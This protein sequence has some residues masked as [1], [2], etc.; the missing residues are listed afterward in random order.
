MTGMTTKIVS[1]KIIL[2]DKIFDGFI[3]INDGKISEVSAIDRKADETYDLTSLYVSPGFIETHTHGGIG[4]SF[5]TG[6]A[7]EMVRACNFHLEHGATTIAPTVSAAPFE[8]MKN[9]TKNISEAKKSDKLLGNILGA[10]LEGPYLSPKQCGA[11]F[12][13]FIT[14][15]IKEEYEALVAELGKDIAR[16]TYAPENDADGEFCRFITENGILASA[17]H[18]DAT[19]PDMDTAIKNGCGLI[20]HLYS[21]T[22]TVTRKGGFRSLGVIESAYLRDELLCEIIADGKHLP[23]ELINM[24]CKIKGYDKILAVTDSLELAGTDA[25]HGFMG[26]TEYII[27]DGVCKL[28]DRSAFAGSIATSDRLIKV[29]TVD[30]GIP[31][32]YAVKMLTQNPARL[33]SLNKGEIKQ[34]FDADLVVFDENIDIKNV[35]VNGI[36]VYKK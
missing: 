34:G 26:A 35:F 11:Q 10:H 12:P 23:P 8:Q 20:T 13:D 27:E 7:D 31:L 19:L 17:G 24:I 22:S 6:S 2:E 21:C 28:C 30:C 36:C 32:V 1:D 9:A 4:L 18:T 3:Y 16:W 5:L 15:P 29:L 25:T 33:F 14:H